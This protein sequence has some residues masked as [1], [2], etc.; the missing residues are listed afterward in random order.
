M[1]KLSFLGERAALPVWKRESLKWQG[2]SYR[3]GYETGKA[4][5]S[6]RSKIF[7]ISLS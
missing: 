3:F 1:V 4:A 7:V 6:P 5:R 2:K